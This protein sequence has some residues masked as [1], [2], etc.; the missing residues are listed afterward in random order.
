M[1]VDSQLA[2]TINEGA[3]ARAVAGLGIAA[4]SENSAREELDA[5]KLVRML[6]DWDFGSMEVNA[7]F[8]N[9]KTIKPAARAFTDFL[10]RE[11]RAAED[12]SA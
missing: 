7:L 12:G 11:L 4:S 3:M 2:I 5:G 9:G 6:P 10:L 8:A 1:R